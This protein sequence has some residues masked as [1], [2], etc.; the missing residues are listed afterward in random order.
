MIK[1]KAKEPRE[2]IKLNEEGALVVKDYTYMKWALNPFK[3]RYTNAKN[4]MDWIEKYRPTKIDASKPTYDAYYARQYDTYKKK[5][6]EFKW[7]FDLWNLLF[8]K[9]K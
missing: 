6:E 1:R 5:A 8:K 2:P 9:E 7:A 3:L 4:G